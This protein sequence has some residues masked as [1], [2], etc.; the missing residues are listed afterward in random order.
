MKKISFRIIAAIISCS[1][2]IALLVGMT[3][4]IQSSS[5]VTDEANDNMMFLAKD[6]ANK[7]DKTIVSVQNSVNNLNSILINTLDIDRL[8]TDPNYI[9]EYENMLNPLVK[10]TAEG[11]AGSMGAYVVID[12]SLTGTEHGAWYADVDLSG[13]F[14]PQKLTKASEYKPDNPA[15][16]WYYATV[17]AKKGTWTDPYINGENKV[18]MISYTAPVYKDDVLI[19]VVGM[20]VPF[21]SFKKQILSIKVYKTGDA[22][23]LNSNYQFT[24]SSTY[25]KHENFSEVAN[26][27]YKPYM[28]EMKKAPS[29]IISWKF[30]GVKKLVGYSQLSSGSIIVITVPEQEVLGK[31]NSLRLLIFS[32][33]GL[34]IIFGLVVA[35]FIGKRISTPITKVTNLINKT[36]NFD[37]VN[38]S[39]FDNLLT[40]KDETGIMANSMANMR[41]SLRNLVE[42]LSGVIDISNKNARTV[43]ELVKG[44]Q[45][46]INETSATT[47]ELSAGIEETAASTEE[48]TATVQEVETALNSIVEKVEEGVAFSDEIAKRAEGLTQQTGKAITE[49]IAIYKNVKVNLEEG[50]NQAKSVEQINVLAKSILDITSQTNLLALNAAIEAARAGEAGRGFSVV[51]DEIRKL[52]EQSA[53]T[54]SEIQ[55]IIEVVNS[56]V[57]NLSNGAGDI[58]KFLEE[59]VYVDYS[60]FGKMGEQYSKDAS[61]LYS[62]MTDF[63]A[64]AEELSASVSNISTAITE[65]AGTI[66]EA[67]AGVEN[68]AN[69]MSGITQGADNIEKSTDKSAKSSLELKYMISKFKM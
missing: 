25:T 39:S 41:K 45:E 38:D 69:R 35:I 9:M 43:E 40:L 18:N 62:M 48:V 15:M 29:G 54:A 42:K 13:S 34:G 68:I 12:P 26:G 21:D 56:S 11:T 20:D 4:I 66:G 36:E 14:K 19:G 53:S 44:I 51:A 50:I 37:L 28:E 64:T 8:N 17:N 3:G 59:K 10:S 32:I 27:F 65:I 16:V 7:I 47:E 24:V 30:D 23:L 1:V 6:E 2:I 67:S 55:K 60:N 52:A 57:S 22:F 49:G 63:S 31:L 33:I 5:V 46:D 61:T 58:L